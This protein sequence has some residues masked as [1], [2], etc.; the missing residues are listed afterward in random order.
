MRAAGIAIVALVVL[1]LFGLPSGPALADAGG[2]DLAFA[3]DADADAEEE[4]ADA[5]ENAEEEGDAEDEEDDDEDKGPEFEEVVEDFQHLEGL[6]D[7]YLDP[8]ENKVYLAIE[9]SQFGQV[10]LCSVT[11]SQGDGYFFDSASLMHPSGLGW[12]TFP[13]TFERVGKKVFF[14]HKNVYYTA[15]ADAAISRAVDRGLSDSVLGTSMIEGQPHPET[16]AVLVDPSG[17]FVQDIGLVSF[18]FDEHIKRVSYSYD[19]DNSYIGDLKNYPQNTEIDVVVHFSTSAPKVNVPTVPDFRSFQHTY[20]YSLS[21]IPDSDYQPRLGDDRVGHFLTL[22]QDYTSVLKDSPYVRYINRWHLE[23]AEPR[24]KQSPP[25]QPIVF[26]IENT[27]PVEYRDAV[28]E[29]I[30]L[31][32]KAFERIGFKDAI[33]VEVQPDDADWDAGDAR[34][35]TVRWMVQ[36]GGGYAVGPSRTNPYTGEIFDADIRISADLLRYVFLEY[37]EYADPV[38]ILKGRRQA[39]GDSVAV[40]LGRPHRAGFCDMMDGMAMEAGFGWQ[41]LQ[42]RS[43]GRLSDED[44]EEYIRQFIVEVMCHEVGHT[45]GLRHNFKASTVHA[46]GDLHNTQLTGTQGVSGSVMDYNPVNLAPE[47]ETQGDYYQTAL[48]PYDYWAIEYAYKPVDRDDPDSEQAALAKI[49]ARGTDPGLQYG[50]DEDAH[51]GTRGIDPTATRWDLGDRPIEFYRQRVA[52][53]RELWRNLEKHFEKKGERYQKLRR[54]FGQGFRPYW[55][56]VG[57]VSRYIGGIY[58]H[59]DH[60]GD[61]RG[62][63]P[64]IPV[65][66][67]VQREALAYLVDYVFGPNAFQWS[68]ELLNKLAP[69]RFQ[70]FTWSQYSMVRLDYPAHDIVLAIQRQP[71]ARFYNGLFLKRLEDLQ[72]RTDAEDPFDMSELFSGLRTAIWAELDGGGN[73]DSFR[74]NLQREHLRHLVSMVVKLSPG[75][76]EDARSL[77]RVDLM[78]INAGIEPALSSPGL[79]AITAAHLTEV[80]AQ[81]QAALEAGLQRQL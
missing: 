22:R 8:E 47:G 33:V 23:K 51:Y 32:N 59:R 31:W 3:A 55:S 44:L 50:T 19:G 49:A 58:Y 65:E 60:V 13:M 14:K 10:F 28:A 53:S 15:E 68:P 36:P 80:A 1:A 6:F 77:A 64:M 67:E 41:V 9:P 69:E 81:I 40:A 54:V 63:V 79:D 16:A 37:D 2:R 35:S 48:G 24:F 57:N 66:P 38:S 52:L 62:R 72:L 71:L 70:D 27:V 61:P 29:G 78:A 20:H 30:L 42:A 17:F 34:H 12:G 21:S 56:G 5:D 45:L 43:G 18:I 4:A 11:R 39:P 25:K 26:W 7:L 76:P 74:R 75:A 46:L 73:V